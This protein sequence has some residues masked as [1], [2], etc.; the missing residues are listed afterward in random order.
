MKNEIPQVVAQLIEAQKHFDSTSYASCFTETAIVFD[1]G[2]N[3]SGR[4][5]IREWIEKANQEYKISMIPLE[6]SESDQT[7]KAEVKG[8]FPGSPI[9][10]NYQYEFNDGLIQ[11]LKIV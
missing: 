6:Y 5:Q 4:R 8:Q 2:K 3:Y 9:V 7:L 10:L 11:S 1:E